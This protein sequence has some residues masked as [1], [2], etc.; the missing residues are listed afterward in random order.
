M[1]VLGVNLL[2]RFDE[3]SKITFENITLHEDKFKVKMYLPEGLKNK[4]HRLTYM[5]EGWPCCTNVK[6]CPLAA[7]ARWTRLRGSSNA[8]SF[9]SIGR[10]GLLRPGSKNNPSDLARDMRS[11][12]RDI[13]FRS[14]EYLST[15]SMRRGG[16]H[17]YARQGM[18]YERIMIK[19][20]WSDYSAFQRYL[21]AS[22]RSCDLRPD[23]AMA[24]EISLTVERLRRQEELIA[25]IKSV[26]ESSAASVATGGQLRNTLLSMIDSR[27]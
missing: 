23:S 13:G 6:A 16:A 11:M 26:L 1:T 2:L 27:I 10:D 7:L 15:H 21:S 9:R 19:G 14:V 24:A 18:R 4:A 17:F 8:P 20:G 22:N 25:K 12:L 3:L 5:L